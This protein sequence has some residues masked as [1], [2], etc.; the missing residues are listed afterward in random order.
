[1]NTHEYWMGIA[2]EEAKKAV[3]E[4]EIPVGAILVQ[5]QS[6]I[7]FSHNLT[8]QRQ[9]PLAHAE[10]NVIEA[11]LSKEKYFYDYTLY[12]TLEPC[13][14]C[15]GLIILS[16]I[17]TVVYG[18]KDKKA[19]ACGSIYN[20]LKDQRFNHEPVLISGVLES[21]CSDILKTFFRN[22]RNESFV[23]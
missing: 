4:D 14:M 12:V 9:N 16:R 15:A 11:V 8:R 6:L 1:M 17:G 7:S 22:K 23:K 18:A 2:L 19:G 20:V 10:K 3:L 21:E 13:M 5:K